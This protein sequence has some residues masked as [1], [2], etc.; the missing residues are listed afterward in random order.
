M[1]EQIVKNK[2]IPKV[3]SEEVRDQ[4]GELINR[5]VYRNERMI[6]TRRGKDVMA[7]ISISDFELLE[8]IFDILEDQNDRSIIKQRLATYDETGESISLEQFE[9]ELLG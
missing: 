2:V 7:L 5:V 4:L 9:S 1:M 6:V 8:K 3:T